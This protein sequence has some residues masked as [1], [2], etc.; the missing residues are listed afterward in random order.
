MSN[1]KEVTEE[2]GPDEPKVKSAAD[3]AAPVEVQLE[4]PEPQAFPIA[5][6]RWR[7][8]NTQGDKVLEQAHRVEQLGKTL[9][10]MWKEVETIPFGNV[11]D[12]TK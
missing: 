6:I 2:Q 3:Q 10:V 11:V 8:I 12:P 9:G 4:T 5:A 7:E 1:A